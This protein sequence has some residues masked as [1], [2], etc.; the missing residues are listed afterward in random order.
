MSSTVEGLDRGVVGTES[1]IKKMH[2]LVALGKLDPTFQKIATWIRASVS[3]DPRAKTAATAD[4]VF[5]WV[6]KH[7]IFQPDPFQIEKIEHPIEAMRPIIEARRA[8]TY[9]GPGLFVGDC[10]TFSIVTATLGGILGFQYAFETAKVDRLR[11][12][13]YSHVWTSL[14]VGKDWR[15]LDSSTPGVGPGWRPPVDEKLFAREPRAAAIV[16]RRCGGRADGCHRALGA[17]RSREMSNDGGRTRVQRREPPVAGRHPGCAG[18]SRPAA[19]AGSTGR[20]RDFH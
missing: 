11:P 16:A 1:T 15:A 9:T 5:N 4:A 12:D 8:G 2:K 17:R 19:T 20:S 14:L 3:S 6:Q 10:D 18:V 13:E 7:G